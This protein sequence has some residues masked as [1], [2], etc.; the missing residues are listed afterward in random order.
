MVVWVSRESTLARRAGTFRVG[1][2]AG[3]FRVSSR[4]C[5][6][7]FSLFL[8]DPITRSGLL[9][10]R[11]EFPSV[12]RR[13]CFCFSS[14]LCMTKDREFSSRRSFIM[15]HCACV[16]YYIL[17]IF[18]YVIL[19]LTFPAPRCNNANKDTR[20]G[21]GEKR[22]KMFI[23]TNLERSIFSYAPFVRALYRRLFRVN[24]N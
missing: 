7:P 24:L 16:W 17:Q 5:R 15:L 13:S 6:G 21:H 11:S 8:S 22:W 19:P 3:P 10:R 4:A 9:P 14:K 20:R 18:S 1:C 23:L 2:Y 12:I